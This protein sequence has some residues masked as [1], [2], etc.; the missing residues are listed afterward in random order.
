MDGRIFL[1]KYVLSRIVF[2]FGFILFR[3]RCACIRQLSA[4]LWFVFFLYFTYR[5][6]I[7]LY[8]SEQSVL[9]IDSAF[10]Y[11]CVVFFFEH[12]SFHLFLW[13]SFTSIIRAFIPQ[14]R[15]RRNRLHHPTSGTVMAARSA[16][17]LPLASQFQKTR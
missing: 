8:S 6:L 12:D 5:T 10:L 15:S 4:R 11:T 7:L 2:S 1:P 16:I 3:G 17:I 9:A 13:F 14:G